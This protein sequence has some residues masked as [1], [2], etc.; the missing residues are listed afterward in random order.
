MSKPEEW[1]SSVDRSECTMSCLRWCQSRTTSAGYFQ[2]QP[3]HSVWPAGGEGLVV[4][5][6]VTSWTSAIQIFQLETGL[7]LVL[8]SSNVFPF[9]G[10]KAPGEYPEKILIGFWETVCEGE[11]LQC[12]Y[13]ENLIYYGSLTCLK[14][15][16]QVVT[17]WKMGSVCVLWFSSHRFAWFCPFWQTQTSQI[18]VYELWISLLTTESQYFKELKWNS[19]GL[20]WIVSLILFK[21]AAIK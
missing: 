7:L 19:G 11:A 1:L 10:A 15:I 13:S 14:G 9:F 17:G 8:T 16:S 18:L 21:N 3:G 12:S 4:Q 2:P 6:H 5:L 20:V